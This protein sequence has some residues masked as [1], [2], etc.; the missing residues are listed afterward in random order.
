MMAQL[1][2]VHSMERAPAPRADHMIISQMVADGAHVLDVGCG[3]GAL[4]KLL[5]R[6]CGARVRGLERNAALVRVCVKSGLSVVQ[7]DASSDLAAFPDDAFDVVVFSHTLEHLPDPAGALREASRVGK[8]VVAS[9]H[10][11]GHWP[12]RFQLMFTGRAAPVRAGAAAP[13]GYSIRDFADLARGAGLRIE[14]GAPLSGVQA[15]A[16][17][18]QTLWRAN[19]FAEQAVFLLEA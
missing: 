1:E 6:E 7:G 18:A 15:G 9:I 3:D 5:R 2:L 17:F 13:C 10:N 4:M 8:R 11:A 14:R 16:P 19:W 12:K